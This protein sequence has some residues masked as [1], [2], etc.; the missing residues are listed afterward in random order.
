MSA[1][2][3]LCTG[4]Q[5]RLGMTIPI[6]SVDVVVVDAVSVTYVTCSA[7]FDLEGTKW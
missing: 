5:Y 1:M 7:G 2:G 4:V 3:S 6:Y